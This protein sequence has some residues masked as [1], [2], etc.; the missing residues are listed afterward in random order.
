M[1]TGP[2][3]YRQICESRRRGGIVIDP[4]RESALN[5]NSYNLRLADKLLIYEK[6]AQRH[7]LYTQLTWQTQAPWSVEPLDMAVE[8]KT[9]SLTIPKE[10]LVLWP[11]IL[12]LGST[13]EYTETPEHVPAIEGRSSVGRLGVFVHVTAG[14]GDQNFKG[15]W[16]L[17][18]AVIRP[19]RVYAG[20]DICQISYHEPV[21]R[22]M[23][24]RG[25]YQGQRG[26]KPSGLWR[27][28]LPLGHAEA[29]TAIDT[30]AITW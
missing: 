27:D 6:D 17:E 7:Q 28:F 18:L 11:G 9:V 15:D 20:V 16:T 25:R 19:V 4:F 13:V 21:G 3:I 12:Y 30:P 10:G 23:P 24:Y 26:P 1:L 2:E 8:E 5:P 22:P 14:F 29:A